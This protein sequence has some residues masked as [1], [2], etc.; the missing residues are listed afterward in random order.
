MFDINEKLD[1]CSLVYTAALSRPAVCSKWDRADVAGLAEAT[2]QHS[3]DMQ[4]AV[5]GD[6]QR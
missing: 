6:G 1:N 4:S 5:T 2:L 3:V